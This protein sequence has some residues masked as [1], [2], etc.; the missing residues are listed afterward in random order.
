MQKGKT[1]IMFDETTTAASNFVVMM[2]HVALI[3][4]S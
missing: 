3:S 1:L 4:H 2:T